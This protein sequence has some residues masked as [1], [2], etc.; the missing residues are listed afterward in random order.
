MSLWNP[1]VW[2]TNSDHVHVQSMCPNGAMTIQDSCATTHYDC[3]T[4]LRMLLVM[5]GSVALL[6]LGS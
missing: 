3:D 5:F 2:A 4:Q 6:W 1:G